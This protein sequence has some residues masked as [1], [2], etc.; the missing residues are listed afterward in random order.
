M[1]RMV[2]SLTAD[3]VSGPLLLY[4]SLDRVGSE[5]LS[6]RVHGAALLTSRTE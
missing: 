4:K 5:M 6:G 1:K 3:T 2:F